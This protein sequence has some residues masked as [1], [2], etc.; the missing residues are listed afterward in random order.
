[1]VYWIS[2]DWLSIEVRQEYEVGRDWSNEVLGWLFSK[3]C[4]C[5]ETKLCS[6]SLNAWSSKHPDYTWSTSVPASYLNE[7][8][9]LK[10]TCLPHLVLVPCYY[11][12]RVNRAN[13]IQLTC[14][15]V[16]L[17]A[18][19]SITFTPTAC[20]RVTTSSGRINTGQTESTLWSL[21]LICFWIHPWLGYMTVL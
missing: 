20:T 13:D 2:K 17:P 8:L 11:E 1:M 10:T 12:C 14:L 21:T 16:W 7:N 5:E 6:V 19:K 3:E 15:C 9:V 4:D 18:I